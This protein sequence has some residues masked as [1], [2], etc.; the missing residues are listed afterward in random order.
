MIFEKDHCCGLFKM[1][2]IRHFWQNSRKTHKIA[3]R[4]YAPSSHFMRSFASLAKINNTN[5]R[6]SQKVKN[7]LFFRNKFRKTQKFFTFFVKNDSIFSYALKPPRRKS[8]PYGL[9]GPAAK[10]PKICV[11]PEKCEKSEIFRENS[12]NRHGIAQNASL[13][14]NSCPIFAISCL[15]CRNH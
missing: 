7:F 13:F 15:K 4:H 3:K 1:P 5:L 9:F 8:S 14:G 12:K 2:K 11:L 6:K 10:R